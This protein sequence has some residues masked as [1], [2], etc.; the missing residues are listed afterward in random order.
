MESAIV[1]DVF[2]TYKEKNLIYYTPREEKVN[3]FSHLAGSIFGAIATVY[4]VIISS[5]AWAVLASLFFGFGIILTYTNSAIYHGLKDLALKSLWRKV[6]H[7]SVGFIVVACG[8][9][10]C[11]G[12]TGQVF[13][14]AVFGM[15]LSVCFVNVALCAVDLKKF[16]KIAFILDFVNAGLL[17]AVYFYNRSVIPQLSKLYYIIGVS[18]CLSGVLFFGRKKEF[19]HAVFHILM[20][21]GT[22]AFF[23][24][25][26]Y[27]VRI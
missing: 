10:L 24:A 12:M 5:G 25:S 15:G 18:L 11:L 9:P 23:F 6:D 7:S 21:L 14:Y 13:N 3:T 8:A 22:V 17:T 16:S 2:E 19:L 27:I 26:V 1:T 4:L 20:V